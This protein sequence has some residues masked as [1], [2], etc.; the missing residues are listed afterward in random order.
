MA[1]SRSDKR[2]QLKSSL[3]L[4]V[5]GGQTGADRAA[6]DFAIEHKIRHG[7]WCPKGRVAEDGRI[8]TRYRLKETKSAYPAVRTRRN[9]RDSEGTVIFSLRKRLIGG[10]RLTAELARRYKKPLLKVVAPGRY[11][12]RSL[13]AFIRKHQIRVLNVAGPRESGQP[14]IYASTKR[15]LEQANR[16][17]SDCP[18]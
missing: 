14:G 7:G 12:G 2:E 16:V 10:T 13:A 1:K 6:L 15:V 9:V 3:R 18:D 17:L 8:A 11:V 5:S 4:I